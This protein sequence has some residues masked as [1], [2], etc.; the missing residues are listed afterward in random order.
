LSASQPFGWSKI[1]MSRRRRKAENK[2][3]MKVG[4]MWLLYII[5]RKE[6]MLINY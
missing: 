5:K 2:V 1:D 4:R 3:R 6:N